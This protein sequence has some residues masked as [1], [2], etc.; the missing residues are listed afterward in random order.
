[1]LLITREV[2]TWILNNPKAG[3]K[4]IE[5]YGLLL[6]E[7]LQEYKETFRIQATLELRKKI[8]ELVEE[9]YPLLDYLVIDQESFKRLKEESNIKVWKRIGKKTLISSVEHEAIAESLLV[10]SKEELIVLGLLLS[11]GRRYSEIQINNFDLDIENPNNLIFG[12]QLKKKEEEKELYSIPCLVE[13]KYILKGILSLEEGKNNI[14]DKSF[15]Q[16]VSRLS[17]FLFGHKVHSL[18][19]KYCS[20][21]L[22]K[23]GLLEKDS[24]GEPLLRA[25]ELLG[26]ELES[27]ATFAYREFA[28]SDKP[29]KEEEEKELE[30]KISFIDNWERTK[31]SKGRRIGTNDLNKELESFFQGEHLTL[32]WL[33]FQRLYLRLY[34]EKH[35]KQLWKQKLKEFYL[36]KH[37]ELEE[38]TLESKTP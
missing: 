11:T 9:D 36:M 16:R 30:K 32:G 38:A 24:L 3:D 8:K 17:H 13:R 33:A 10:S 14:N 15:Y 20:L 18:R 27:D 35:K 19:A 22:A 6:Q 23:E 1:M 4:E 2:L 25:K 12:G 5:S 26:H 29:L 34:Y 37:K 21:I 7:K 31:A 28:I